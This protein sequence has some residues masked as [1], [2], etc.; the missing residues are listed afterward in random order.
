M[1]E[2]FLFKTCTGLKFSGCPTTQHL[3]LQLILDSSHSIE[4]NT[5]LDLLDYLKLE[6]VKSVFSTKDSQLAITRYGT[7]VEVLQ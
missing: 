4:E 2:K 7:T 3:D 6:F 1:T 5:W